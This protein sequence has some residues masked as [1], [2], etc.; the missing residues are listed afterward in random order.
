MIIYFALV[1]FFYV[2]T[3]INTLINISFTEYRP[4]CIA[5]E[6]YS[7]NSFISLL[8]T[9]GF[10]SGIWKYLVCFMHY[11]L[12]H[13]HNIILTLLEL[14]IKLGVL[15][16]YLSRWLYSSHHNFSLKLQVNYSGRRLEGFGMSDG[17]V[18]E[19]LWS[20]LRPTAK[21]T[22]EMTPAHRVDAITDFLMHYARKSISTLGNFCVNLEF[23]LMKKI[24]LIPLV[25][26]G[27][28]VRFSQHYPYRK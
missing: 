8:W 20:Y 3:L 15:V 24:I 14:F 9:Q 10:L 6:C 11:C 5:S 4:G 26:L 27:T 17:E 22:K 18:M 2:Q 23:L 28:A 21:I 12:W 25:F 16:S 7:C 1:R 13:K 19:R